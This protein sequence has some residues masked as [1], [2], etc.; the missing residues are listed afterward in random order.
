[1]CAGEEGNSPLSHTP[2]VPHSVVYPRETV[3]IVVPQGILIRF[4]SAVSTFCCEKF[5]SLRYICWSS[6]NKDMATVA[7]TGKNTGRLWDDIYAHVSHLWSYII[8]SSDIKFWGIFI[9]GNKNYFLLNSMKSR[10]LIRGDSPDGQNNPD[11]GIA[12]IF[13]QVRFKVNL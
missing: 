7:I 4:W 13:V 3:T 8:M 10:N 11:L 9:S 5:L 6:V 2:K 12:L 1:M